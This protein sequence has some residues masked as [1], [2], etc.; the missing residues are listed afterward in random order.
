MTRI[1]YSPSSEDHS[2]VIDKRA[3]EILSYLYLNPRKSHR[4]IVKNTSVEHER[5]LYECIKECLLIDTTG[6]VAVHG[7]DQLTLQGDKTVNIELTNDGEK[8]VEEYKSEIAVSFSVEQHVNMLQETRR[9][10]KSDLEEMN[11]I[12]GEFENTGRSEPRL[13]ELME[14]IEGYFDHLRSEPVSPKGFPDEE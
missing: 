6:F 14:R 7:S 5:E 3:Q 1:I 8:F 4:D 10:I 2:Y 13:E 11:N 12:L 9:G